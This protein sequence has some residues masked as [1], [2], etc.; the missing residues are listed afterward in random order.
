MKLTANILTENETRGCYTIRTE[1]LDVLILRDD[2]RALIVDAFILA[3]LDAFGV[4]EHCQ[5]LWLYDLLIE[6]APKS[7]ALTWLLRTAASIDNERAG[8]VIT[9]DFNEVPHDV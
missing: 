9:I 4:W 2:E 6:R 8:L 5:A 7:E 3:T 1:P